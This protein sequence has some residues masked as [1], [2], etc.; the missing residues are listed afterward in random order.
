MMIPPDPDLP[1]FHNVN[2]GS[3][4]APQPPPLPEAGPMPGTEA[5]DPGPLAPES[6]AQQRID[7]ENMLDRLKRVQ[8]G[9]D[10]AIRAL[11]CELALVEM[12]KGYGQLAIAMARAQ[13]YLAASFWDGKPNL[14]AELLEAIAM[15]ERALS[16]QQ[17]MREA[18]E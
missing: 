18:A 15:G 9:T 11:Q 14:K 16:A 1:R 12:V 17:P 3:V 2:N 5:G 4:Q 7:M 10:M 13:T 8:D 6:I